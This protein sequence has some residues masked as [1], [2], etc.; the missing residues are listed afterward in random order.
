L[1]LLVLRPNWLM[2]QLGLKTSNAKAIAARI[3]QKRPK[4]QIERRIFL[5]LRS[6]RTGERNW[7]LV[8]QSTSNPHSS[9]AFY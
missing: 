9:P 2:N 3:D 5:P 8:K 7:L 1:A 4:R 6:T